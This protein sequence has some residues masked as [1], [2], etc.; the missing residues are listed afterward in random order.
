MY[1]IMFIDNSIY[2]NSVIIINIINYGYNNINSDVQDVLFT[3]QFKSIKKVI[4]IK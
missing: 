4:K 1:W 2:I 3:L